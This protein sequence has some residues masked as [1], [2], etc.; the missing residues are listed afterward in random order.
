MKNFY[1][2]LLM[3]TLSTYFLAES[4]TLIPRRFYPSSTLQ[5]GMNTINESML[6]QRWRVEPVENKNLPLRNSVSC[7]LA[8]VL[9]FSHVERCEAEIADIFAAAS[10]NAEITY[11][12]NAKNLNRLSSGDSS[13]GS[14]YNNY[15]KNDVAAKRRALTG[16]KSDLARQRAEAN[17]NEKECNLRVFNG[18]YEFMLETLRS[19]DCPSCPYGIG[20]PK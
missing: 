19:L 15:P 11:S 18:D 4:F 2:Y 10:R 5:M 7:L 8:L 6:F 20:V 16:C 13:G 12:Q 14:V 17:M 3:I 9:L 1:L